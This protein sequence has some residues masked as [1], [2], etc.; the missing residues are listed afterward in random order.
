MEIWRKIQ[1]ANAICALVAVVLSV[2]ACYFPNLVYVAMWTWSVTLWLFMFL[3]PMPVIERNKHHN[4]A[5]MA[6]SFFVAVAVAVGVDGWL[7]RYP[8]TDGFSR[9][10]LVY[11]V[12]Y[13]IIALLYAWWLKI[14]E[15]NENK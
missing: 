15:R 7:E 13:T 2:M 3:V 14:K 12:A 10:M 1:I 11:S 9:G 8:E 6:L 4:Q 5:T